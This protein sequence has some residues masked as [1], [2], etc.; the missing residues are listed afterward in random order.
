M[1]IRSPPDFMIFHINNCSPALK[2]YRIKKFKV[3]LYPKQKFILKIGGGH[4]EDNKIGNIEAKQ[5][6][7]NL[8]IKSE[9][10]AF[11]ESF[12]FNKFYDDKEYKKFVQSTEKLI[13]MSKEYKTYVELLRTNLQGLNF[14]NILSNI[15]NLD[16]E[17]EFHHYPVTLYE[18]VDIIMTDKL[19][20]KKQFTSFTIAKEVMDLHYKN[21]IGLVPLTKMNHELA[22][23]GDIFISKKQIFG[24]YN[25]FLKIYSK[26]VSAS[27]NEKIKEMEELSDKNAPSDIQGLY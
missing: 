15:T 22:H 25:E 19:L 10:T 13:R 9:N 4:M 21:L 2:L 3:C 12:Y 20:S 7:G 16:A 18:V 23:S 27:L 8:V 5:V 24:R 14:D 6:D 1:A 26:S 11:A 17:M